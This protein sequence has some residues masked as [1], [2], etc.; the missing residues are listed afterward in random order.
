MSRRV[1]CSTSWCN[2]TA[3]CQCLLCGDIPYCSMC[4]PKKLWHICFN[5]DQLERYKYYVSSHIPASDGGVRRTNHIISLIA[6]LF[7][8]STMKEIDDI[9][10]IS[11]ESIGSDSFGCTLNCE[12]V[13]KQN[14]EETK[15]SY[16]LYSSKIATPD[17]GGCY[18][19]KLEFDKKE[20]G[21]KYKLLQQIRKLNPNAPC[22]ESPQTERLIQA[23][24]AF[25]LNSSLSTSQPAVTPAP[26]SN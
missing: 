19:N 3:T 11:C 5:C 8:N 10:Y 17:A 2:E 16:E 12:I 23:L 1:K 26:A 13:K 14:D 25:T 9:W 4:R 15:E 6:P 24:N 21:Y 18:R 22:C 7:A 20:H